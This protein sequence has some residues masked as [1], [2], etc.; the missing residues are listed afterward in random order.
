MLGTKN[1]D[2][3]SYS[4]VGSRPKRDW[5]ILVIVGRLLGF[6]LSGSG[7]KQ[8]SKENLL[9]IFIGNWGFRRVSPGVQVM[10]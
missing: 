1:A 5:N 9:V 2:G 7:I 6:R 8:H 3:F 4:T 10:M